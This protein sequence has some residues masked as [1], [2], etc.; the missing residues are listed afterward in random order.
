MSTLCRLVLPSTLSS[1]EEACVVEFNEYKKRMKEISHNKSSS[2]RFASATGGL[3][4]NPLSSQDSP[5]DHH[6]KKESTRNPEHAKE[7][8]K[9]LVQ[10]GAIKVQT[11]SKD[12]GF[13]RASSSS[14]TVGQERHSKKVGLTPNTASPLTSN[15]S[16]VFQA[17][18]FVN[19]SSTAKFAN[20]NSHESK[21]SVI[22]YD[23]TDNY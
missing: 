20:I 21:R 17:I 18:S 8:A 22:N 4:T 13:K 2:K 6:H 3:T 5:R 9:K 23:D 19:S 15:Q 7:V 14:S 16:N 12:H 10:S 1:I 11:Q